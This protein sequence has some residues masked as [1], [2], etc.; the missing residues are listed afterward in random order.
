MNKKKIFSLLLICFLSVPVSPFS[1]LAQKVQAVESNVSYFMKDRK[2]VLLLKDDNKGVRIFSNKEGHVSES[3]L[4]DGELKVINN[5]I[6]GNYKEAALYNN[7]LYFL[8]KNSVYKFKDNN[9]EEYV[10]ISSNDYDD[11]I[12]QLIDIKFDNNGNLYILGNNVIYVIDTD[13][14]IHRINILEMNLNEEIR[15]N[16]LLKDNSGIIYLV[17]RTWEKKVKLFKLDNQ[18]CRQVNFRLKDGR[19]P[20][21]IFLNENDELEFVYYDDENDYMVYKLDENNMMEKDMK[22]NNQGSSMMEAYSAINEL[23]KT[24][25]GKLVLW[26]GSNMLYIKEAGEEYFKCAYDVAPNDH[27]TSM[28]TGADGKIYIGTYNEGIICYDDSIKD[29]SRDSNTDLQKEPS[30]MPSN[31]SN[32]VIEKEVSIDK[33]W[34]IKF[35]TELDSQS[36][37]ENNILV[38]DEYGV[39]QNVKIYLERDSR[40]II[41]V[42]KEDYKNGQDYYIIIKETVKALAGNNLDKP[43]LVKFSTKTTGENKNKENIKEDESENK[44]QENIKDENE[45]TKKENTVEEKNENIVDSSEL[46]VKFELVEPENLENREKSFIDFIINEW[47]NSVEKDAEISGVTTKVAKVAIKDFK[48]EDDTAYVLFSTEILNKKDENVIKDTRNIKLN[49]KK[50]DGIWKIEK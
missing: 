8:S 12:K 42:P 10:K 45:D 27:I 11:G 46:N 5:G 14:N 25:A 30:S 32:S 43:V 33:K 40:T 13:K 38:I 9:L 20:V 29:S 24:K 50:Y 21:N 16:K 7:E 37:N 19:E 49:A 17:S 36:V 34:K 1:F 23:K 15:N 4:K 44:N 48:I 26:I 2:S 35:N 3:L 41:I 31:N 18:N 28:I 39:K 22:F 47:K 6:A